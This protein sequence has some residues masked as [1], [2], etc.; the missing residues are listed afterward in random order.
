MH[1]FIYLFCEGESGEEQG[2]RGRERER[3]NLE[4]A[5]CPVQSLMLGFILQPQSSCPEPKS[6]ESD[7]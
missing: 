2:E 5:P 7:A 6:R 3:E 4:R 1:L